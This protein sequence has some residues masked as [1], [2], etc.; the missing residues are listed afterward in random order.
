[1]ARGNANEATTA[2]ETVRELR[3]DIAAARAGGRHLREALGQ[4]RIERDKVL[5][6]TQSGINEIDRAFAT[7]P[8][9]SLDAVPERVTVRM[10][11]ET[12]DFLGAPSPPVEPV[13]ACLSCGGVHDDPRK[14]PVPCV[15]PFHR[16]PVEPE[17][18]TLEARIRRLI[19]GNGVALDLLARGADGRPPRSPSLRELLT[20]PTDV[21][22]AMHNRF[23]WAV[24]TGPQHPDATVEKAVETI[25]APL[26]EHLADAL[27]PR[28]EQA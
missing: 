12:A 25:I 22:E 20:I 1:M 10:S 8:P 5:A 19:E 27:E 26:M 18:E 21:L 14:V 15:D 9:S 2:W 11:R 3:A 16:E 17:E 7:S 6:T 13:R 28:G 24:E 4:A 23:M